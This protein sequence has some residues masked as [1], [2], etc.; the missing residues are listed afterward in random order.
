MRQAASNADRNGTGLQADIISGGEHRIER[1][2]EGDTVS[3]VRSPLQT[4]A[5]RFF[6][7]LPLENCATRENACCTD[8]R[9]HA[10]ISADIVLHNVK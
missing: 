8:G 7:Q 2:I 10:I 6:P 3:F 4:S 1:I 5:Y 9:T